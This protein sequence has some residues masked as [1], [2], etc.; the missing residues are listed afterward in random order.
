MSHEYTDYREPFRLIL[1]SNLESMV[2]VLVPRFWDMRGNV[3]GKCEKIKGRL[4]PDGNCRYKVIG[5]TIQCG[6]TI[7]NRTVLVALDR[8]RRI[9]AN[10][11]REDLVIT[12]R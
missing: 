4:V 3:I 9:S 12:L 11:L 1:E 2:T 5:E 8:V 10:S 7:T 6:Y